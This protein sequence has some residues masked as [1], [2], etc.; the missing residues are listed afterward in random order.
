MSIRF[1]KVGQQIIIFFRKGDLC[2][3]AKASYNYLKFLKDEGRP[4]S[5]TNL[6]SNLAP[7]ISIDNVQLLKEEN[8]DYKVKV[9]GTFILWQNKKEVSPLKELNVQ[10]LEH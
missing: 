7:A 6:G 4:I 8:G 10:S 2:S 9:K 3:T 5:F 1:P